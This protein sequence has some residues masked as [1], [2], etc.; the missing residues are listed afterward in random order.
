M[1]YIRY[2]I[3]PHPLGIGDNIRHGIEALGELSD[4][5]AAFNAAS[6]IIISACEFGDRSVDLN[7]WPC[8]PS[9]YYKRNRSGNQ[10]RNQHGGKN[11]EIKRFQRCVN[12]RH[13]I[14]DQH[15]AYN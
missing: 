10:E 13:I 5:I 7:Y 6:R 4:L 1:R 12:P 11:V 14:M 15:Y 3:T 9:C 2:E 8:Y